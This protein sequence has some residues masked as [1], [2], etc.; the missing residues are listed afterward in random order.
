MLPKQ[1][2]SSAFANEL[3]GG[4]PDHQILMGA[5]SGTLPS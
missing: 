5:S 2:S 3:F 4:E 1:K